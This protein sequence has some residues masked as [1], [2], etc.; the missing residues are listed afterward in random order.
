MLARL[1]TTITNKDMIIRTWRAKSSKNQ[2]N[3][4][5]ATVR[6]VVLPRFE[7]IPGY[8]GSLFLRRLTQDKSDYLVLTCWESIEH[9]KNFFGP[10]IGVAY[11][12]PPIQE[13]LDEFDQTADHFDVVIRHGNKL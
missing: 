3:E 10:D 8:L 2:E 5:L 1:D 9:V 11:V 4:Y 7:Q 6:R 12:P 13:T